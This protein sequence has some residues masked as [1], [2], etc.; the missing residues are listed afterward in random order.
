MG[1][2][3]ARRRRYPLLA[4]QGCGYVLGRPLS[5]LPP[6]FRQDRADSYTYR[7]HVFAAG[8]ELRLELQWASNRAGSMCR[9]LGCSGSKPLQLAVNKCFELA[10]LPWGLKHPSKFRKIGPRN[11]VRR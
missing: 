9:D 1:R 10:L 6:V 5:G 7:S 11:R 4:L 2:C 3:T 8:D